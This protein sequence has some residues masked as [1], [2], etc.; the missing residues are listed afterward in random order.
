MT[1]GQRASDS[2]MNR[3]RALPSV[4]ALSGLVLAL[5]CSID[6]CAQQVLIDDFATNQATLIVNPGPGSQI[7]S[8]ASGS[9]IGGGRV[10]RVSASTGGVMSGGV[11]GGLYTFTRAA[12]PAGT[13]EMWWDGDADTNF[14]LGLGADFTANG[15]NQFLL[16]VIASNS[17]VL[18]MR[19]T[20]YT[21]G[22]D[23]SQANFT[24]PNGGVVEVPYSSFSVTGGTGADF[25]NVNNLF[26]SVVNVS[27]GWTATLDGIRAER[28]VAI[29][30]N[31][32]E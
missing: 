21:T 9:S 20:A 14:N 24:V 12:G 15:M 17:A 30:A 31:G 4:G 23:V 11:N 3:G 25:S 7:S 22:G 5:F 6:A 27:G 10:L 18:Q 26:L 16:T 2:A 32:F 19:L 13:S 8:V 29:F 28:R 1:I